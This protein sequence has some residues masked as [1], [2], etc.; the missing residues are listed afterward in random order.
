MKNRIAKKDWKVGDVCFFVA[1]DDSAQNWVISKIKG[2]M[3]VL[4]NVK[5]TSKLEFELL[6][7]LKERVSNER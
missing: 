7:N 3:A 1:Q 5:N 2:K 4:S 6:A